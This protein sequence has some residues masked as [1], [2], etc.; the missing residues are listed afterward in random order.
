MARAWIG[1]AS[2]VNI[3]A[4]DKFASRTGQKG[5]LSLILA[6]MSF[7]FSGSTGISPD[8]LINPDAFPSR[9]TL[10]M[11]AECCSSKVG[12]GGGM[13]H[14]CGSYGV[15]LG[16]CSEELG[17]NGDF[18]WR[19][20]SENMMS[21][22]CGRGVN[23]RTFVGI[24]YYDRLRQLVFEKFQTCSLAGGSSGLNGPSK[25]RELG[26]GMRV[27]EMERGAFLAHGAVHLL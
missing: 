17:P 25:G 13:G 6:G 9:M 1:L 7:P 19:F 22:C 2:L 24:V 11:L 4:G 18:L 21:G 15:Y 23:T 12:A 10:G 16:R 26:G 20:G 14:A 8:L 27:G 5:V 3:V